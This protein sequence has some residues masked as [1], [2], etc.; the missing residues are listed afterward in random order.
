MTNVI[1]IRSEANE[2]EARTTLD[3]LCLKRA[4]LL[5]HRALEVEVAESLEQPCDARNERR[6]ALVTR[7]GAARSRQVTTGAGT[8]TVEAPRVRVGGEDHRCT[9]AVLP[10][11]RRRS[12]KIAD[13]LGA[14]SPG[15]VDG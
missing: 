10:P 4:R 2:S 5:L 11:C 7:N 3:A 6:Y 14:V 15:R 13:G 9:S 12:L 1:E 8:M